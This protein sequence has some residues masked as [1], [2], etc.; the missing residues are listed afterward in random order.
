MEFW[1][2]FGVL[3]GSILPDI[4]ERHSKI[5]RWS[6]ILGILIAFFAKHRGFFHS[7]LFFLS[8]TFLLHFLGQP[9]FGWGVLLGYASHLILDGLTPQ[10]VAPFWPLSSWKM[11][12]PLRTGSFAEH[13]LFLFLVILVIVGIFP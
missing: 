11:R 8:L 1:L 7:V 10:G 5:N 4:D 6:G 2:F 12:G 9:A 13:V 3:L